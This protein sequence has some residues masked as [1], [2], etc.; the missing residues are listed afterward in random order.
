MVALT[1]V[2]YAQSDGYNMMSQLDLALL[3]VLCRMILR[4]LFTASTYPLA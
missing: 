1:N 3:I 4:D 2:R